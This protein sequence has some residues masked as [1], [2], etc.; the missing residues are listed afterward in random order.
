[1]LARPCCCH[2][3]LGKE[4]NLAAV[5]YCSGERVKRHEIAVWWYLS[6]SMSGGE[7]RVEEGASCR[8]AAA[9]RDTPDVAENL[10]FNLSLGTDSSCEVNLALF[11]LM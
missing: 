7:N 6:C 9:G 1:M 10:F 8:T 11:L 2:T 5:V 3:F 4:E